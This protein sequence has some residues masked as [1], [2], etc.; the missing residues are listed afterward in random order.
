MQKAASSAIDEFEKVKKMRYDSEA[1]V[2]AVSEKVKALFDKIRRYKPTQIDH[3]VGYLSDLRMLM[4]EI[5]SLKDLRYVSMTLIGEFETKTIEK[6]DELSQNCVNFLLKGDSLKPY[7]KKLDQAKTS[8]SKISK[9]AE[10]DQASEEID[11]IAHELELL[12]DIVNN[13]K[14]DDATQTVQ[15]IDNISGIYT[16]INTLRANVKTSRKELRGTEAVQ[17]FQAQLKLLDQGLVNYLDLCDTADKCE[18]YLTKLMIQIEEL[19]GKFSEFESF[20]PQITEKRE[21]IYQAFETRKLYLLEKRNKRATHLMAAAERI[22]QGIRNRLSKFKEI[23]EINAYFAADLMIAKIRDMIDE[24][25]KLGDSVKSGDLQTRL[26]TLRE[27]A[28]RQLKDRTDLFTEG[29]NIIRLGRHHFAV[30]ERN[31]DL[32]VVNRNK[33][34]CLPFNGNQ[35]LRTNRGC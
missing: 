7:D 6:T 29:E 15:I 3:F 22:L 35:F 19:E 20:I 2:N 11:Q 10:A 12:I 32:T 5:I 17:E 8:V 18:E 33:E 9:V 28:I 34:M 25:S 24:L 21:E 30:S 23:N 1:A 31:L 27:E 26:K 4:G 13:L 16:G 14:I